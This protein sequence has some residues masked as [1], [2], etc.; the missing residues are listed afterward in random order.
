[1]A[2]A[3]LR[4]MDRPSLL[5]PHTY[6]HSVTCIFG[7]KAWTK[8]STPV[9]SNLPKYSCRLTGEDMQTHAHKL[10]CCLVRKGKSARADNAPSQPSLASSC[11]G[12][13]RKCDLQESWPDLG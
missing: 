1:M 6:I 2:G 4:G 7:T 3:G 13:A 8:R 10:N 12:M 11:Y 5:R 9:F